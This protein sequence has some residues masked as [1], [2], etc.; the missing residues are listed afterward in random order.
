MTGS[1]AAAPETRAVDSPADSADGLRAYLFGLRNV[2]AHRAGHV[3]PALASG[4]GP[5][6]PKTDPVPFLQALNIWFHLLK[7]VDGLAANGDA[8][9]GAIEAGVRARV[10]E[11]CARFPLYTDI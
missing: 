10:A 6:S 11:L 8:G 9:N 4:Q 3:L 1:G 7:I 5:R 2:I